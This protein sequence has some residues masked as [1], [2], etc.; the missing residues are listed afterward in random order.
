MKN[1]SK[2]ISTN[3]RNTQDTIVGNVT[4]K[5]DNSS[6]K[7]E[8]STVYSII[9]ENYTINGNQLISQTYFNDGLS[10]SII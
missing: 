6:H 4:W 3:D 5:Y 7:W 1:I 8:F 10:R 9:S 2:S